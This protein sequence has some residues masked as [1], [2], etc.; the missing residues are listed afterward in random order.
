MRKPRKK[1]FLTW[2]MI[3]FLGLVFL[4]L[5]ASLPPYLQQRQLAQEAEALRAEI[6]ALRQDR[7]LLERQKEWLSTDEYVEQVARQQLGL[8]RPGEVVIIR[9][10][11]GQGE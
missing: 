9:A 5:L 2:K 7:I 3:I 4:F 6:E 11:V 8:V 1:P 10:N